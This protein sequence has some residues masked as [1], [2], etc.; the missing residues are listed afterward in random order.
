MRKEER[1]KIM[2]KG[3]YFFVNVCGIAGFLHVGFAMAITL[4]RSIAQTVN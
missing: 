2:K 1:K 3:V 4:E